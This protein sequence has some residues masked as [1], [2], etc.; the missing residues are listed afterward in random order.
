MAAKIKMTTTAYLKYS[1][2]ILSSTR[3]IFA[4][5]NVMTGSSNEIPKPISNF[6]KKP[7]YSPMLGSAVKS[8]PPKFTKNVKPS[9]MTT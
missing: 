6:V 7:T 5:K 8:W 2:S 9:G 4:K 1:F 3:P